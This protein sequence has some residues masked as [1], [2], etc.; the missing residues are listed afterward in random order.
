LIKM[1][2]EKDSRQRIL[3]AALKEFS[4]HGFSGARIER[5]ARSARINKAMI[6]YYFSSKKKLYQR[7]VREVLEQFVPMITGLIA[8]NPTA[9]DF[10]ERL[11]SLYVGFV[12]R[13]P[14]FVRMVAMELIQNPVNITSIFTGIIREKTEQGLHGPVQ[15]IGL[16]EKWIAENSVSEKDPFQFMLNIVSLSLLFLLGI[17]FLEA[18]FQL[19]PD[20][21]QAALRGDEFYQKRAESIVNILK[22]GMLT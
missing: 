11:P 20:G 19:S 15:M 3:K 2:Q 10:L 12:S 17:P 7:V 14:D 1:K 21:T 9:E 8:A 4:L 6:F 16:I 13:H 5:I 22:R 18:V